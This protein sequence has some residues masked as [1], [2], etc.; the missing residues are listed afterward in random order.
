MELSKPTYRAYVCCGRNCGPRGSLQLLQE[1]EAMVEQQHLGDIV[2][3]LPTGCQAHCES[4]PTM[5]VYPGPTYYQEVDSR[6]LSRIVA[7]HFVKKVPVKD[8]FWTGFQARLD[9][10]AWQTRA[11]TQFSKLEAKEQAQAAPPRKKSH[12]RHTVSDADDFK[13]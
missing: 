5:V 10:P 4:G 8:Y 13:W 12:E 7:E 6:S 3:V 11:A 2:T 9:R 1:L